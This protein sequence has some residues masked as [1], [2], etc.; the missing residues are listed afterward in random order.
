MHV[1]LSTFEAD[2][3]NPLFDYILFKGRFKAKSLLSI[4]GGVNRIFHVINFPK[5]NQT[6]EEF[7]SVL[8]NSCLIN[9][10][11]S[12]MVIREQMRHLSESMIDYIAKY[13][14]GKD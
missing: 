6:L 14:V 1:N 10:N 5:A 7:F 12:R 9:S 11:L 4:P 8:G 3:N 13:Q 2:S